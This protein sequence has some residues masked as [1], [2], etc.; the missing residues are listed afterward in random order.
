MFMHKHLNFFLRTLLLFSVFAML[1]FDVQPLF[2]QG[3]GIV[4]IAEPQG[5]FTPNPSNPGITTGTPLTEA[6]LP[7]PDMT[8]ADN[9]PI[10]S[11]ILDASGNPALPPVTS[12]SG[13]GTGDQIDETDNQIYNTAVWLAGWIV[14]FSGSV[15]D[16][17]MD[18]IV[19][20]MG[21][22]F[23]NDTTATRKGENCTYLADDGTKVTVGLD[24]AVGDVVNEL[25]SVVRDLFNI[26]FIFALV[27]IGLRMIL[28]ANDSN[29]QKT[30]GMLIAAA[31]LINFSL[32]F[33]KA[34]VDVTNY[35]AVA[36]H[37]VAIDGMSGNFGF[38]VGELQADGSV[39]KVS[40]EDAA[41][42]YEGAN[43]AGDY[44]LADAYMQ[45]LKISSWFSGAP[46]QNTARVV[47]YAIILLLFS[48]ILAITLFYGAIMLISRFI[49]LVILMIFSPAMFLGW[50]LPGFQKHASAWWNKFLSYAFFAPAYIF[51]LYLGLYTL[52]Q[53][54]NGM[55]GMG[56]YADALGSTWKPEMFTIFLFYALGIG[57]LMAATK[58]GQNMSVAGS[59]LAMNTTQGA[60]RKM[61][62]GALRLGG[63][64]SAGLVARAG[65]NSLG[66]G[67]QRIA[68]SEKL[69][70]RAATS[71]L[72]RTTLRGSR[73]VGNASFDAR[74]VG[75]M[76]KKLGIGEGKKGGYKTQ[77]DAITKKEQDFAASLG[78]VGDDDSTIKMMSENKKEREDTLAELKAA[79]AGLTEPRDKENNARAMATTERQIKEIE[80]N[81]KRER[82]R[83]QIGTGDIE[84]L[85]SEKEKRAQAKKQLKLLKQQF[86]DIEPSDKAAKK[87]MAK[88]ITTQEKAMKDIDRAIKERVGELGY[89]GV[90]ENRKF[91]L[92]SMWYGRILN[93]DHT[94]GKEIRKKYE[95][96]VKK[97]KEDS[98][99]DDVVSAVKDSKSS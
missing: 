36:I 38:E 9:N 43:K 68:D 33:T 20:K 39:G 77:R 62:S 22:W 64:A 75:S 52:I 55:S 46:M 93:Q 82:N 42:T 86:R 3:N 47:V 76:G 61:R 88:K 44:N 14:A 98:R 27:W 34:I 31:L 37:A 28:S 41:G 91:L 95:K 65:R 59:T 50:I 15:F 96:S 2:A 18:K 81:I 71:A 94:A 66:W 97:S 29:A 70:D 60:L 17:A 10:N 74:R 35:T 4:P 87:E 49:A 90:L 72:A 63:A 84:E 40:G 1:A 79:K 57:F 54:S 24:G 23:T 67:A 53:L 21:C 12:S 85:S 16:G 69:K 25:W 30:L 51:M 7:P 26:L 80:E 92:G 19:L 48:I 5:T 56:S 11:P 45:A 8:T 58:V 6:V 78:T 73:L 32:Y 13:G 83:R 99:F 89:A